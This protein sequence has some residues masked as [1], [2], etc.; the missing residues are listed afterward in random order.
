[1]YVRGL[2]VV[3]SNRGATRCCLQHFDVDLIV[4]QVASDPSSARCT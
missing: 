3:N 2:G 4:P 1:M